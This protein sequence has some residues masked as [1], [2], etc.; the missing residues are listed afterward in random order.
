MSLWSTIARKAL[1]ALTGLFLCVFLVVHLG[2]NLLLVLPPD[3]AR[4]LFNAYAE[5]LSGHP[6]IRVVSLVLYSAL[7]VHV[8]DAAWIVVR[9]RRA[10]GPA[11]AL[12]RRAESSRWASRHM[13]L[14][15]TVLL[16]FL[17]AHLRD[18]WWVYKFGAVPLDPDGHRDLYAVVRATFAPAW[19]VGLH[20]LAFVGLGL[21]LWHGAFAATQTLGLHHPGARR[22]ARVG[23][24]LFSI[25]VTVGFSVVALAVHLRA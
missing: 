11:P 21:H 4:P 24:A 15:G 1:M 5:A 3:E 13:G 20:L 16:V 7:V 10:A 9:N 22:V 23:G 12:D 2:G 6:V 8:V 14:L 19:V 25:A 17:I 18:L